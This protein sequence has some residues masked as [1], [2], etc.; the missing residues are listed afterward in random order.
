[1]RVTDVQTVCYILCHTRFR[2]TYSKI[3]VFRPGNREGFTQLD[4][5]N[6]TQLPSPFGEACLP[7]RQGREPARLSHS[8]GDEVGHVET[9]LLLILILF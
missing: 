2:N 5:V 6:N 8:A 3:L 1:M 4:V 9:P 7:A